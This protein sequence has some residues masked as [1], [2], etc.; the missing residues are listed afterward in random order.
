[1]AVLPVSRYRTRTENLFFNW[2]NNC[3]AALHVLVFE[4]PFS[5]YLDQQAYRMIFQF[6]RK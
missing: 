3:K 6:V 5:L 2:W 4:G 1:M